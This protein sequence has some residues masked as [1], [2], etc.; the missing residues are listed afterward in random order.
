MRQHILVEG[1]NDLHVIL[2]LWKS[3]GL[4]DAKGY[5]KKKFAVLADGKDNLPLKIAELL[6]ASDIENIG[7]VVDADSSAQNTWHSIRSLL[8]KKGFDNLPKQLLPEGVIIEKRGFPKVGIWIMPNNQEPLLENEVAYLEH[9]YEYL[10]K[11][12]DKFLPKAN[13]IVEEIAEDIDR[14]FSTTH[15]QKAKIH[16]WLAWQAEPGSAMGQTIR[17]RNLF[18]LDGIL[19]INFK[20]WL[21]KTFELEE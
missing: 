12:D 17:N 20:N 4:N 16:T 1:Q 15:L 6:A 9:F 5:N 11:K 8:E 10:I 19:A 7:I 2:N 3:F 21:Q 14:R 13:R 18:D